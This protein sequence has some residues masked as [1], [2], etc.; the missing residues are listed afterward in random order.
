MAKWHDIRD[1][2]PERN[3]LLR[4]EIIR[5]IR[6]ADGPEPAIKHT[7]WM[8]CALFEGHGVFKDWNERNPFFLRS[9]MQILWKYWED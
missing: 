2:E 7:I 3:R 1:R 6:E 8:G 4:M 9:D 5:V